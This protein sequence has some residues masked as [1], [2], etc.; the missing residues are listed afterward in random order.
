MSP[1][2]L[3]DAFARTYSP[4]NGLD[5]IELREEY[6]QFVEYR[7]DNPNAGRYK[8]ANVLDIP[9]G[10][11]RSW[12]DGSKPDVVRGAEIADNH[13]WFRTT[14]DT[15]IALTRLVAGIFAGGSI[16]EL[17]TPR[18]SA[19]DDVELTS[20]LQ[21]IGAGVHKITRDSSQQGDEI[22][23]ASHPRVLGRV[24]VAR[25]APRDHVSNYEL[26]S[27]LLD[28]DDTG[29]AFVETYVAARGVIPE[30]RMHI[31]IVEHQRSNEFYEDL[32]TLIDRH[33]NGDVSLGEN[34][35]RILSDTVAQTT[36][37]NEYK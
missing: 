2:S 5:P 17:W 18:W 12:I 8:T 31:Q 21:T 34:G 35:V 26:P 22:E 11:A 7:A 33:T 37:L 36:W 30:D 6:Q 10:R 23:P 32:H 4:P 16:N 27:Y 25:G 3:R 13:S 1:E 29:R 20:H 9:K 24:L 14:G 19:A 15:H 28:D